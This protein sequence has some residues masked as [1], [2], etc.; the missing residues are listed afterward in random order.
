MSTSKLHLGLDVHK[1]SIT[2]ANAPSTPPREVRLLGTITNHL[3]ALERTVT[4]LRKAHPDTQLEAAY[5]AGPCGFGIARLLRAGE[6][7]PV[8]I[9]E[10][11]D[12]A[13]RDLCRAR[14]DAVDDQRPCANASRVASCATATATRARPTGPMPTCVTCVNRSCPIPP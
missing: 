3:H 13:I 14:T 9:P 10:P 11:T 2:L 6:L 1:D 7:T 8:Y 12:E 4:R 5:E